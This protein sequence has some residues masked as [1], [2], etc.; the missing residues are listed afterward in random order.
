MNG[1]KQFECKL[2]TF[3]RHFDARNGFLVQVKPAGKYYGCWIFVYHCLFFRKL[4][5]IYSL[6]VLCSCLN[7]MLFLERN[8]DMGMHAILG[9]MQILM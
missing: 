9:T 8:V 7:N 1:S 5:R 3:S 4:E 6:H 2:C